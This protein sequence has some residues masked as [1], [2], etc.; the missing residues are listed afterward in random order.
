MGKYIFVDRRIRKIEED[1]LK[2]MGYKI[3]KVSYMNSVYEEISSHV[4]I[5][6]LKLDDTLIIQRKMYEELLKSSSQFNEFLSEI[7]SLALALP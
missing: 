3:I 2:K 1:T 5:F 6:I 4:D 7:I